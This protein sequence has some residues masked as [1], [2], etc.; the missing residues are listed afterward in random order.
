MELSEINNAP[1]IAGIYYFK[2]KL[3]NKYYI[4]QAIRL[5]KRLL[6]HLFNFKNDR[7]DAPLYKAFLKYGLDN[8]EIGILDTFE[9]T[10]Y[11]QIKFELDALEKRYI[12]EYNSYGSTGYNQTLGGDAG[13]L[14]LKMTN[15]QKEHISENV[16]QVNADGR[17]M[18]YIY[19]ILEKCYYTF[20]NS[21][22]AAK[23]LNVND[24]SLRN[25]N[26]LHCKRYL[27]GRS[28]EELENNIE[29]YKKSLSVNKIG[30]PK[31]YSVE[32]LKTM[33]RDDFISKYKICKKT[34][35]NWK[36]QLY[37]SKRFN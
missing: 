34:Y 24:C 22:Y 6:Y 23:H 14:G 18:F 21:Q 30:V 35:Y 37:G 33:T 2:N 11:R 25:R 3:N 31:K 7:Y 8:F 15:E 32:D 5:R 36:N 19:D 16:K 26:L 17:H 4:G 12:Q 20:I 9:G 28:K 1:N 13:V 29:R 27:T 10:D